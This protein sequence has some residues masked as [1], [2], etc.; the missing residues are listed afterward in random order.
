MASD[1][2]RIHNFEEK[3][4]QLWEEDINLHI[5]WCDALIDLLKSLTEISFSSEKIIEINLTQ[6]KLVFVSKRLS[7]LKNIVRKTDPLELVNIHIEDIIDVELHAMLAAS[8]LTNKRI[9]E[10]PRPK[11]GIMIYLLMPYTTM[12]YHVKMFLYKIQMDNMKKKVKKII[13]KRGK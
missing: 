7:K 6:K 3:I 4:F 10:I 11:I 5:N 9:L 13:E 1:D 12:S 2:S 8:D